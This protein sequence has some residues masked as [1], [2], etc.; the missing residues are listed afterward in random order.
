M[1][2]LKRYSGYLNEAVKFN[3]PTEFDNL[4]LSVSKNKA[5]KLEGLLIKDI[6]SNFTQSI[7]LPKEF[8]SL[9]TQEK[10][11]FLYDKHINELY[12]AYLEKLGSVIDYLSQN[13][14]TVNNLKE[15]Y[16]ISEE[17]HNSL[18]SKADS[19]EKVIRE[20]E[21]NETDIFI[22]FPN[23]WYWINL[24]VDY[25]EDERDNMGHCGSDSGKIL[26]S[27]RDDNRNS[28]ITVSYDPNTNAMHQCKGR[29]NT[30]P[31]PEYHQY[32][33]DLLLNEKY[34]INTILTGS[35]KPELDFN[36]NDLTEELR[37]NLLS[38]K[39]IFRIQQ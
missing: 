4:I 9:P 19:N 7:E 35:Y 13:D 36:L 27:L 39:T 1:K 18:I 2:Y 21:I 34:P 29:K 3:L 20:D 28:H 22:E 31:K 8:N 38:K 15:L 37:N 33:I 5:K 17:W 30:K 11:Y 6:L 32:I 24:K 10:L 12:D 25:S 16:N 14:L 23:N 26:L